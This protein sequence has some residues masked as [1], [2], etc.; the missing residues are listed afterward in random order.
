MLKIE[1]ETELCSLTNRIFHDIWSKK[2]NFELFHNIKFHI[3][4]NSI[5]I[6]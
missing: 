1:T 4:S 5:D 2:I 6:L 3:L